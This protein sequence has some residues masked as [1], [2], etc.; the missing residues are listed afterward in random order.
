V[1]P[2]PQLSP[3]AAYENRRLESI[4]A[5]WDAKAADWDRNLQDPSCH[6]NEDDA[7][8]SF[9][10]KLA[11][12]L[13]RREKFCAGHGV[14]DAGCGTGLVLARIISSFAWG[15]GVDISPQMIRAAEAKQIPNA[16]FVIGDCFDLSAS[17]PR[18]GAIL[19]RGVLLSHYGREHATAL[20]RSANSVLAPGGFIFWDFLNKAG[21]GKYQHTPEN[22]TFFDS[23]GLCDLA[24][25]AGFQ[26]ATISGERDRRVRLLIAESS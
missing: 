2:D 23:S 20:L 19:S 21:V 26:S 13:Q 12:V 1:T 18:A 22:K 3:K 9:L 11:P 15:I 6:L 5:R 16:R 14:I 4:A 10:L 24:I 8:D 25:Q 7:Y 17:C